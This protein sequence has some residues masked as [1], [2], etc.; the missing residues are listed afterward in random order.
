MT[1]L[2][3][4]NYHYMRTALLLILAYWHIPCFAEN[5][6]IQYDP[7]CVDVLE[8]ESVDQTGKKSHSWTYQV[9]LNPSE[10]IQF[11]LSNEGIQQQDYLPGQMLSCYNLNLNAKLVETVN[12]GLD[13]A[14]LVRP[15]GNKIEVV[16]ILSATR[17]KIEN[18]KLSYTAKD[19]NFLFDLEFG[20][21]GENLTGQT[22]QF[23]SF[24]G[25]LHE[26]CTRSY[27]FRKK[28]MITPTGRAAGSV[29]NST[30][31]LF[32]KELG[33]IEETMTDPATGAPVSI[34]KLIKSNGKPTAVYIQEICAGA[35]TRPVNPVLINGDQAPVETP[36]GYDVV[37]NPPSVTPNETP[38]STDPCLQVSGNGVHIVRKNETLGKIAKQYGLTVSGLK[39]QNG[40]TSDIIYP[41]TKLDVSKTA[42]VT[43][44]TTNPP[45]Y[46]IIASKSGEGVPAPSSYEVMEGP[47]PAAWQTTNGYH[48]VQPGENVALVAMKYGY[49][50]S[51]FR[52]M[53][54][55]SAGEALKPGQRL[56]T[57]DCPDPGAVKT[58]SLS[59]YS[60]L[61]AKT[62]EASES[63]YFFISPQNNTPKTPSS[64]EETSK[65]PI[66]GGSP[67]SPFPGAKD[68][69]ILKGYDDPSPKRITNPQ[70]MHTVQ[71]G[72]TL[73]SIARMYG[74]TADK[75]KQINGFDNTEVLIPYQRVIIR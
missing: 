71:E 48:I 14:F 12:K 66:I 42:Q 74:T 41:C 27:I 36:K 58:P 68:D 72:E 28:D 57:Q 73:Y 61:T 54:D 52:I 21:G 55:L 59:E 40:L 8:Y 9:L 7:A 34:K 4:Q 35:M 43:A 1:L 63:Q 47:K 20:F 3:T 69:P 33:F 25:T 29:K 18:N 5:Y 32:V 10:R 38:Q 53:N 60:V 65:N 67:F 15:R 75:L 24:E 46:E 19:F 23:I 64:Y 50:E 22:G 45:A 56:K 11:S 6:Y 16:P 39:Q 17:I 13:R 30:D 51:R 62:P 49:T 2:Q 37:I 44:F 26:Y 31:L 70:V